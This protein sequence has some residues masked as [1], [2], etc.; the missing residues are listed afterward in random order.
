[1]FKQ[2]AATFK[3]PLTR[4]VPGPLLRQMAFE[5]QTFWKMAR[6]SRST[7]NKHAAMD[8]I[9]VNIGCGRSPAPGWVNLDLVS[10]PLVT[11]WDGRKGLPFKD[12][13]VSIIFSEHF[14]E[15]LEYEGEALAFLQ[16]CRRCL[17]ASGVL[18][19]IVPDAGAYL[20]AYEGDDWS[21]IARL[22]PLVKDAD[23]YRD[24][25]INERYATKMQVINAV[26]RQYGEHKY[27]Y[28]AETL[29]HLMHKAGFTKADRVSF[30]ASAAPDM[31]S[32]K[33]ER[34][35]ESLY[36]EAVKLS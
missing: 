23:G 20:K 29:I 10:H 8:G 21:E 31:I 27:A 35:S 19:I 4:A 16:E 22:R 14:F 2:L 34:E 11:Y 12:G 25:W 18:R 28:D 26:F 15:H 30:G 7:R 6:T 24:Y 33:P 5:F 13:T 3:R 1:M 9:K 36:V 32:G 17:K